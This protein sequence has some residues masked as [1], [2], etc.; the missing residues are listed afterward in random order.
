[1]RSQQILLAERP[2]GAVLESNFRLVE[3][4]LPPL[5]DGQLLVRNHYL[6][7]DPYRRRRMDAAR[8]YAPSVELG[9]VMVGSAVGE[10]I[11]SR[12]AAYS[13]GDSVVGAFGWQSHAISNGTGIITVDPSVVPLRAYLGVVGMPGVTAHYGLLELAKPRAGETVVVSAA[14]GAVGSIVGQLAKLHGARAVGIAGGAAKC[15]HVVDDLGFDACVDYRASDFLD[16]LARATPNGIDIDFENVGGAVMD[17]VLARLNPFARVTLC[18]VIS[19]YD[20]A[21]YGLQNYPALLTNRVRLQGFII[22]D[23]MQYWPG[24]LKELATLV[25]GNKLVYRETIAEGLHNA[26]RAFLGMLA[27]ANTGKQLVKLL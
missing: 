18:G 6:S 2:S 4:E 8:S 7:L 5:E 1:M 15:A 26:P 9:H 21:G 24:A 22:S 10:V 17:S 16:Q 13:A 11:E 19:N 23:H 25:A 14:A 20:G 3:T 27:G 12:H